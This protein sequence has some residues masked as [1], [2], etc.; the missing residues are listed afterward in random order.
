MNLGE[1]FYRQTLREES[2][3]A[4]VDGEVRRSYC[5]WYREILAVAG[6]LELQGLKSGD[7]FVAVLSNRY[8][9]ATLYWACQMLG[10]IFTPFNWRAN[11]EE[12]GYVLDDA[13]AVAVAF[14]ARSREAV[15]TSL[16]QTGIAGIKTYD[17]DNNGFHILKN[18]EPL[19]G[20]SKVDENEICLMLYTSGT[21]GRPKGVP[22]T[23]RAERLAATHCVAQLYYR[24]GE[25]TL[26]VMP[27]FHTMGIRSML[28][29]MLLNSKLVCLPSW[30]AE[31]AM[32]LIQ[33]EK[34]DTLFL[35]PTMFHDMLHHPKR[36]EYDLS[37][38]KN[39]GYAGMAMT[40]AL[41]ARCVE[42]FNPRHF[43]NF[44]GSSEIFC[45]AVCDHVAEKP[46]C[47]GRAGI[48]Q[49]LR[50]VMP[51]PSGQGGPNEII[52][53]GQSGEIIAP[54]E[55]MEAFS[56]YWKRPD[57]DAKSIREGWY[58]TGDLGYFDQDGE[59]YLVGRV[60]DMV[61][62]GGE[63]IYPEEVED[64]LA[65]SPLVKQ[66]AVIGMPD[67]RMGSRVVAFVEPA[68]PECSAETLDAWCL[69]SS[70]TRFKRPRAYVF[71]KRIPRSAAGKLLRRFLRDGDYELNDKFNS[72]L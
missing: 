15:I 37:S 5:D 59:L 29:C 56:G 31:T 32:R 70:L 62:S 35:V 1:A 64:V 54:M 53:D 8:E 57:A 39:I 66:V 2:A 14:E 3:E 17:I 18:A 63:N 68:S 67:D 34:I 40:S 58:F 12:V 6:G 44:Y 61:I 23:H 27:M 4:V 22:R 51:D 46:G 16:E 25:S 26:G 60:D 71:V 55:G 42:E 30:D 28:M 49:I 47:A 24:H 69:D 21:T 65:K 52:P 50:I 19:N 20:P 33:G 9:T 13:E 7:H 43:I 11:S 48:G 41:T 45:F 10:A 72:T 36:K 38:S